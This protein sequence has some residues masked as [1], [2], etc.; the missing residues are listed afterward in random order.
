MYS[1]N[2]FSDFFNYNLYQKKMT[3]RDITCTICDCMFPDGGYEA[4]KMPDSNE[5]LYFCDSCMA[6]I[7][8]YQ[9]TAQYKAFVQE[10]RLHLP[11][12]VPKPLS[13]Q[14]K[15]RMERLK[16]QMR[17]ECQQRDIDGNYY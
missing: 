11:P 16:A 17:K 9:T 4:R 2:N 5:I 12:F 15:I 8:V 3:D 13:R 10:A 6:K 14:G 7:P 1:I